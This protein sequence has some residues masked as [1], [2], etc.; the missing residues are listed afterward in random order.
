MCFLFFQTLESTLPSSE[1]EIVCLEIEEAEDDNPQLSEIDISSDENGTSCEKTETPIDENGITFDEN[2]DE[3]TSDENEIPISKEGNTKTKKKSSKTSTNKETAISKGALNKQC[4]QTP[5]SEEKKNSVKKVTAKKS[6]SAEGN[7]PNSDGEKSYQDLT[8]ILEGYGDLLDLLNPNDANSEVDKVVKYIL[9][10]NI[11]VRHLNVALSRFTAS[12][13][14][15]YYAQVKDFDFLKIGRFTHGDLGED[16]L[17]EK[18]WNELVEQVPIHDPKKCINDFSKLKRGEERVLKKRNVIGCFLGQDL[19][20]IRHAADIFHHACTLLQTKNNGK[21]SKEEDTIILEEVRKSGACASTWRKL[22]LV[23]NRNYTDSIANRYKTITDYQYQQKGRWSLTEDEMLLEHL[24]EGKSN[25][26]IEEIKNVAYNDF[27]SFALLLN[28]TQKNVS[29]RWKCTLM[30]ILLSFHY[31]TLH[32]LWRRHFF[33]Y[34]IEKK[35]VA[36]PEINYSDAMS[37]FPE[38]NPSS[39]VTPLKHYAIKQSKLN[40]PLY[41]ILQDCLPTFT[42][43]QEIERV[44][45]FRQEIVRIYEEVKHRH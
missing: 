4:L 22:S 13:G 24:F 23:L 26:G 8:P 20:H 1:D 3:K 12:T 7:K 36:I 35:I 32:K 9:C 16:A 39:L 31:E 33:E 42:D 5:A 34:L 28:R 37:L 41:Q 21:Y 14:P 45:N 6:E 25:V 43:S 18:R 27:K 30:P 38:Q 17:L 11:L 10:K 44:K 15:E 29:N 19:P 40:K 2:E